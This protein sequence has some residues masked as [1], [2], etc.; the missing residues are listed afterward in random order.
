MPIHPRARVSPNPVPRPVS[1]HAVQLGSTFPTVPALALEE[2]RSRKLVDASLNDE[3]IMLHEPRYPEVAA[4]L[5]RDIHGARK[6]FPG[7]PSMYDYEFS[8]SL[9]S[10]H[11]RVKLSSTLPP[12]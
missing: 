3:E 5:F 6:T 1:H 8:Q 2:L 12:G 9:F 10:M 4:V 11:L 7:V